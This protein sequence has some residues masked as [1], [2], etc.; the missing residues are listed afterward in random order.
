M[1]ADAKNGTY[2]GIGLRAVDA[3]GNI[4]EEYH[5]ANQ[6]KQYIQ[7]VVDNRIPKLDLQVTKNSKENPQQGVEDWTNLALHYK[8]QQRQDNPAI[9]KLYYQYVPVHQ[10]QEAIQ[11]GQKPYAEKQWQEMDEAGFGVGAYSQEEEAVNRNGTYYFKMIS[12]CGL[13][14]EIASR[15]IRL[16]QTLPEAMEPIITNDQG[17]EWYHARSL[18]ASIVI[19]CKTYLQGCVQRKSMGH[20]LPF[21]QD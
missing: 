10:V 17:E 7:L 15:Q 5:L 6:H 19:D 14:S 13:E 3:A 12:M 18:P 16:Q 8:M 1:Q 20:P 2:Q 21:I 4:S 9:Y 11:K